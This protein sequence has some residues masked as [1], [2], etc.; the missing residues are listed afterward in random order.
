M[1]GYTWGPA[2]VFWRQ[3]EADGCIGWAPLPPG[4]VFVDGGWLFHGVRYGVDF[5][6]G[7]GEG[8]F[9]FIGYG[10]FQDDF[11]RM[12]GR[13]YAFHVSRER[14]HTFYGRTVLRNDFRR[15]EHGR[16]INDGM[17]RDHIEQLTHHQVA[18]AHFE[19]RKP[20]GDI[21]KLN[22]QRI[23]EARRQVGPQV[24]KPGEPGHEQPGKPVEQPVAPT[25]VNKVFRPPVQTPKPNAI[26][27]KP[28]QAPQQVQKNDKQ[29]H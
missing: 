3:A 29:Q 20:V 9:A 7:L 21:N 23:E 17:G 27:P 12:R 14:I 10:H 4:A 15:D 28:A 16:L 5:D 19:E 22:A 18:V 8:Y 13:E 24:G 2:W 25:L 26:L 6:F 11:F 1:P